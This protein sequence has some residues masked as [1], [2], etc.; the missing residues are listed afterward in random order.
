MK[1]KSPATLIKNFIC[2]NFS[3][4]ESCLKIKPP[5]VT[6]LNYHSIS[7]GNSIVDVSP[8]DFKNQI[9]FLKSKFAFISLDQVTAY[10][11]GKLK[12]SKPSVAITFDDGYTDLLKFAT[13]LLA[14]EKIPAAFFVLADPKKAKRKE[15]ENKKPLLTFKQVKKL[16]KMGWTI[17]CH[18]LTHSNF[19]EE[20]NFK[21]EIIKAKTLLEKKLNKKI[22]YFAYPKGIY[23]DK[24]IS[25]IKKSGYKAAFTTKPGIISAKTKLYNVPRLGIDR[26]HSHS[27]FTFLLTKWATVYFSIKMFLEKL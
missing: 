1:N 9:K 22:N 7:R 19:G 14:K 11:Q 18:S 10:I 16:Q 4:L 3:W 25:I 8:K 6:I 15:L 27:Q 5:L 21:T 2:S 23:N 24:I 20:L 26:S 12:L 13:P 17:G